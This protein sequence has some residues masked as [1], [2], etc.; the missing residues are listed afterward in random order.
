MLETDASAAALVS[1]ARIDAEGSTA[2]RR[3]T[4]AASGTAKRPPPAP[5]S[6]QVSE[7]CAKLSRTGSSSDGSWPGRNRA[8]IAA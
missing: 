8:A 2:I 5:M 6:S 4:R 7:G 3:E 1:V